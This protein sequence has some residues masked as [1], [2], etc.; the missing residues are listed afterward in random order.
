M[1]TIIK[2]V[3]TANRTRFFH[4]SG[5]N[6]SG[7]SRLLAPQA[8]F[9]GPALVFASSLQTEI[10]SP[11]QIAYVEIEGSAV[12][13]AVAP[14]FDTYITGMPAGD[15]T[16]EYDLYEG[17][18]RFQ[19]VFY[20]AGGAELHAK[21]EIDNT[22]VSDADRLRRI[23]QLFELPVVRFVTAGG[24]IGLINP[25]VMTRVMITPTGDILPSD[26]ITVDDF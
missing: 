14:E 25:A 16:A 1:T 26:A 2:V 19:V 11:K 17:P 15:V 8:A 4:H 22:N 24:G 5:Q 12:S 6:N 20:F 13:G 3:T 10:Y 18:E 7:I 21:V 9:A 23:S